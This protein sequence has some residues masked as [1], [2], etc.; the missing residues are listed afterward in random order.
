[1]GWLCGG[2]YFRCCSYFKPINASSGTRFMYVFTLFTFTSISVFLLSDY[3]RNNFVDLS[4]VCRT[5]RKNESSVDFICEDLTQ[6]SGVYRILL[7]LSIFHLMLLLMTITTVSNKAFSACLHNGFWFWKHLIIWSLI[8]GSFFVPLS[9]VMTQLM[10]IGIVGGSLFIIVQLLCLYDFAT[11]V[12]LSWERAAI[13][14]GFHWNFLIWTI[15]TLLSVLSLA[16]YIVM[17]HIFTQTPSGKTCFHNLA[18]FGINVTLSSVS[19]LVSFLYLSMNSSSGVLQNSFLCLYIAFLVAASLNSYPKLDNGEKCRD[20]TFIENIIA[21]KEWNLPSNPKALGQNLEPKLDKARLMVSKAEVKPFLIDNFLKWMSIVMA[22][23]SGCYSSIQNVSSFNEMGSI[24]TRPMLFD[25]SNSNPTREHLEEH[26]FAPYIDD[27]KECFKYTYWHLHFVFLCASLYM[28]VTLTNWFDP[29][30]LSNLSDHMHHITHGSIAVFW[31]RS[32][33]ACTCQLLS[34]I[35]I[36]LKL[37]YRNISTPPRWKWFMLS[38]MVSQDH[39]E[40]TINEIS[41]D[42]HNPQEVTST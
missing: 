36:I 16:S 23:L 15:S 21:Q 13:Q 6:P 12:A 26:A 35:T 8:Y 31:V 37:F 19:L 10:I 27:E 17:F 18:I 42:N 22:V 4:D 7:V 20:F 1:M 29:E 9:R 24:P 38:P 14:R 30:E 40:I 33:T 28:M 5:F 39:A 25:C 34:V 11:N 3:V 41:T 32:I 2:D